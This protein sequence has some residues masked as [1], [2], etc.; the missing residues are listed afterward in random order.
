MGEQEFFAAL[1][2]PYNG[3]RLW[4]ARDMIFLKKINPRKLF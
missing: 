2:W 3:L 1:Q 4:A